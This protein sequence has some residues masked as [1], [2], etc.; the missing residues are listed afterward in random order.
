[1]R[2]QFEGFLPADRLPAV[3]DTLVRRPQP[4]RVILDILQGHR[5]GADVAAA[6]AVLGVTLDRGDARGDIGL[7]GD[8]QGQAADGFTQMTG[9][10]MQGLVHGHLLLGCLG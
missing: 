8:F 10:V 9:T 2:G 3:T 4:V 5:L 6:E 7:V 1:M